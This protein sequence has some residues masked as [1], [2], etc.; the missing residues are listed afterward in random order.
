MTLSDFRNNPRFSTV[1]SGLEE[2][3]SG[4]KGREKRKRDRIGEGLRKR[5]GGDTVRNDEHKR[6][7]T[8]QQ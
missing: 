1:C 4:K 6:V 8:N 7:K 2:D 3:E 5:N